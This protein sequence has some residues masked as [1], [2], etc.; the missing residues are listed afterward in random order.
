MS[1]LRE[2]FSF[3]EDMF[4]VRTSFGVYVEGMV[5]CGYIGERYWLGDGGYKN[6]PKRVEV[7]N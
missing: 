6:P 3:V 4:M 7:V 1:L 5:F 2:A